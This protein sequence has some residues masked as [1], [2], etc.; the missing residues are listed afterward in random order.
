M[1]RNQLGDHYKIEYICI[2]DIYY[3][4]YGF[5]FINIKYEIYHTYDMY[6]IFNKYTREN[7][8]KNIN[9]KN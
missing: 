9:V 7:I 8:L 5:V 1:T 3:N 4:I 2:Y 6:G